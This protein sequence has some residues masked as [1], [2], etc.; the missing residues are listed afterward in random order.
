MAQAILEE[1]IQ[2]AD[3]SQLSHRE[4]HSIPVDYIR[5]VC[6]VAPPEESEVVSID[7]EDEEE[8]LR[9]QK[10]NLARTYVR[11]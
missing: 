4:I 6:N 10:N 1:L 3:M 11:Y 7:E 9:Q 8:Q 2:T 5:Q